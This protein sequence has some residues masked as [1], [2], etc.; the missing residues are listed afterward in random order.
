MKLLRKEV[1][2][3]DP[4]TDTVKVFYRYYVDI[5]GIEV[6]LKPQDRTAQQL[7]EVFYTE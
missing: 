3:T 4:K 6:E 7:L 2:W 1:Q 5:N